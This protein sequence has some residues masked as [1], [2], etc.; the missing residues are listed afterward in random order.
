MRRRVKQAITMLLA[1]VMVLGNALPQGGMATVRAE[2]TDMRP[3]MITGIRLV[4][5]TVGDYDN[6][7]IEVTYT[8]E[9]SGVEYIQL[10]FESEP[11]LQ[12]EYIQF[13]ANEEDD[14][15]YVGVE[16]KVV[17]SSR[18]KRAMNDTYTLMDAMICDKNG[19]T[20]YYSPN[21]E[22]EMCAEESEE[23]PTFSQLSY[24]VTEK[25]VLPCMQITDISAVEAE[26]MENVEAGQTLQVSMTIWNNSKIAQYVNPNSAS[27]MW[28]HTE[29]G[30]EVYASPVEEDVDATV[31]EAGESTTFFYNVYVNEY[32]SEGTYK[33]NRASFDWFG[34]EPTYY[35][36]EYSFDEEDTYATFVGYDENTEW[37]SWDLDPSIYKGEADFEVTYAPNPDTEPPVVNSITKDAFNGGTYDEFGITVDA[38]EEGSGIEYIYA[39]YTNMIDDQEY[40]V[41]FNNWLSEEEE[42][43]GAHQ[44]FHLTTGVK[45]ELGTYRLERVEISDRSGK[46]MNY[47]Y[48]ENKNKLVAHYGNTEYTLPSDSFEV[49]K[50]T[51]PKVV[52]VSNISFG[53]E[54]DKNNVSAGD[55][56]PVYM[57]I[58]NS[59]EKDVLIE[60]VSICWKGKES[61]IRAE[62]DEQQE[63]ELLAGE[64]LLLS[65]EIPVSSYAME[66]NYVLSEFGVIMYDSEGTFCAVSQE[67]LDGNN[68][69]WYEE[70]Y[71]SIITANSF[72]NDELYWTV[73][74]APNPD[75]K[76][77][78]LNSIT[79][80]DSFTEGNYDR[81]E[82]T[83]DLTD[84]ESGIRS[85]DAYVAPV[86]KED[87]Y[88][89]EIN[90]GDRCEE[91]E[92][93]GENIALT[94][95]DTSEKVM[96]STYAVTSVYIYDFAGH[97]TS[98]HYNKDTGKLD[99]YET[100]TSI[101]GLTF[102]VTKETPIQAA[103]V[104]D[105]EFVTDKDHVTAGDTLEAQFTIYNELDENLEIGR[106]SG[107][108]KG[109]ASDVRVEVWEW[110]EVYVAPQ[111]S[112]IVTVEIPVSEYSTE[113]TYVLDYLD[114]VFYDG[115]ENEYNISYNSEE[116]YQYW[117]DYKM[118]LVCNIEGKVDFNDAAWTVTE[119]ETPDFSAPSVNSVEVKDFT[120][121]TN[122]KL[123]VDVNLDEDMSGV[124]EIELSFMNL[125]TED[126]WISLDKYYYEDEER[127]VGENLVI[128]LSEVNTK[129]LG[130]YRL[131]SIS[132]RDFAGHTAYYYY[133]YE[134]ETL[135]NERTGKTLDNVIFEVTEE[136][137]PIGVFVTGIT[138][139]GADGF[140]KDNVSAGDEFEVI[141]TLENTTEYDVTLESFDIAWCAN[142]TYDYQSAQWPREV[143]IPKGEQAE[144]RGKISTNKFALT[145]IYEVDCMD[146]YGEAEDGKTCNLWLST[147][148]GSQC[149]DMGD[150]IVNV[151]GKVDFADMSWEI[152]TS[153][154]PDDEAP[155]IKAVRLAEDVIKVPGEAV[156]EM[157]IEYGEAKPVEINV[158]LR[159][160][161][162]NRNQVDLPTVD[163]YYSPDRGC[164]VVIVYADELITSGE[165]CVSWIGIADE[166]EQYRGYEYSGTPG[167]LE[168][169]NNG[170]ILEVDNVTVINEEFTETD[171]S[172]PVL[173]SIQ[174]LETEINA[175]GTIQ[176]EI[177][178]EDESGLGL[179]E[180]YLN[181][182]EGYIGLNSE[183]I[184]AVAG[185]ENTYLCTFSV[186]DM[187]VAGDYQLTDVYL[188]DT[189]VR[190][191]GLGYWV[192][193]G[194]LV[195]DEED[196]EAI[197]YT[198][199]ADFTVVENTSGKIV[200]SGFPSEKELIDA[201]NEQEKGATVY[202]TED[203]V[204]SK[205]TMK[206]LKE[207]EL[208]VYVKGIGDTWI[209]FDA[210][211]IEEDQIQNAHFW[212]ESHGMYE[213]FF[214]ENILGYHEYYYSVYIGA[215]GFNFPGKILIPVSD[216]FAQ[217][218]AED[219]VYYSEY[220]EDG[221]YKTDKTYEVVDGYVEIVLE[222]GLEES[223]E[224]VLSVNEYLMAY[225][226]LDVEVIPDLSSD[227]VKR[228]TSFD[229]E[230]TMTNNSDVPMEYIP[231]VGVLTDSYGN[232]LE[233]EEWCAYTGD[234]NFVEF[235]KEDMGEYYTEATGMIL[236]LEPGQSVTFRATVTIPEDV[237]EERVVVT[238][239]GCIPGETEE[240]IM[241]VYGEDA[242]AITL[243]SKNAVLKGDINL[244][245]SVDMTDLVMML[246]VIVK[247]ISIDDLT[248]EM[249][250]AADVEDADGEITMSD[251]VKML[252]FIVKRIPSLD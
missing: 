94:L 157:D 22:G 179:V 64:H 171:F 58:F 202:F 32:S 149:W 60:N 225:Y 2:E 55:T 130:E 57:E 224:A 34:D 221:M 23:I 128:S 215:D 28:K 147:Y 136:T 172:A 74:D 5:E 129:A 113:D 218:A 112:A 123:T 41:E 51:E 240:D 154:T 19:N 197:P 86:D 76:A 140:S 109:E 43:S 54:F 63:I 160:V 176:Y 18:T 114:V 230:I 105:I 206:A 169:G 100:G 250:E 121:G 89:Y 244:D 228:G 198:G 103:Y 135:K 83:F 72:D 78:V 97:M 29:N 27:L 205:A 24:T 126:E 226:A 48:D 155:Y 137:E 13:N 88:N 184:E 56:V 122:D 7:E 177:V 12:T 175:P 102:E 180:L 234:D 85:I 235:T 220:R 71:S 35:E 15:N 143:E 66:E 49:T 188:A 132:I 106:I 6:V 4:D 73:T 159:D 139:E 194:A 79:I 108:W 104:T 222:N 37:V 8:E 9:G 77:P 107:E 3:P 11:N 31:L 209:Y 219:V 59:S 183:S 153:L 162:N 210:S 208:K 181:S 252:R 119:A 190:E 70:G 191:W 207:K 87:G 168:D 95:G 46:H 182:E 62:D 150:G 26:A 151:A 98:Y 81:V 217:A 170:E 67:F 92:Y 124:E 144:I 161:T 20:Y 127:V 239:A 50:E 199:Q 52:K 232:Q 14:S 68:Q 47:E 192:S 84:T 204:L 17:L 195:C 91:G 231:V 42:T 116:E 53:E 110:P 99:N 156:F 65:F 246:R 227:V 174:A 25:T 96:D 61:Q 251:L 75:S 101:P 185:E 45:K 241:Q 178:A 1:L 141:L 242:F 196:V 134:L 120:G 233:V 214:P 164:Y 165:Y 39:R 243:T 125:D 21:E 44:E 146:I 118:G 142:D 138:F 237:A 36:L 117:H 245:G 173:K 166:A 238:F 213:M 111:S 30:F 212:V 229:A 16:Q 186:D 201:I 38:S 216:T 189:S 167:E 131:D 158:Q 40:H 200:L 152:K 203:N 115:E 145:D 10:H 248:P 93:R 211:D 223:I 187:A 249:V 247:R 236:S 80:G 82:L 69:S 193:D 133:D 90:M 148:D 163:M 33:L